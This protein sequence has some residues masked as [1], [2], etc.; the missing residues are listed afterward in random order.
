[1]LLPLQVLDCCKRPD[2][3]HTICADRQ[4]DV[5]L[6]CGAALGTDLMTIDGEWN[7]FL[8]AIPDIFSAIPKPPQIVLPETEEEI[9]TLV[10]AS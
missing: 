4:R 6:F 2:C 8:K 3:F 7:S 10:S 1:L 5:E 9:G